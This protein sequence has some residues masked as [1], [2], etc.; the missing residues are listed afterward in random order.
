M[1]ITTPIQFIVSYDTIN[2]VVHAYVDQK[3]M[4]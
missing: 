4:H 2:G 3:A 1:G